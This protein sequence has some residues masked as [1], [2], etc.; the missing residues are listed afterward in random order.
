LR[1]S[2]AR[3]VSRNAGTIPKTVPA[4]IDATSVNS[5]TSALIA[6]S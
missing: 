6:I 5:S 4:A 1:L 3:D 2:I